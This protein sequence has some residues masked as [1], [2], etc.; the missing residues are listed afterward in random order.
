MSI[1]AKKNEL[2][3]WILGLNEET[4]LRVD[5]IKNSIS[6]GKIV[7]YTIEGESLT[8]SEYQSELKIA[9]DEIEQGEYYTSDELEKEI[10]KW[11]K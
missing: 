7:A 5:E 3:Q 10:A 9:E 11:K 8:V 4:L 6:S 1:E 2:I